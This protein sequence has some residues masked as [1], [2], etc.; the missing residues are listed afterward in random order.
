[1]SMHVYIHYNKCYGTKIVMA[2]LILHVG[3]SLS[4]LVLSC[5]VYRY[6]LEVYM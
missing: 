1:M 3:S 2:M 5:K 6:I 4:N